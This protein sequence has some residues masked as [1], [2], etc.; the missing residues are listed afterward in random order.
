MGRH[1]P[2]Y[3]CVICNRV[4]TPTRG[5]VCHKCRLTVPNLPNVDEKGAAS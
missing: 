4:R 1:R 3:T 2:R 5:E